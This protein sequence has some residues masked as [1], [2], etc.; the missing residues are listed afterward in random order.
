MIKLFFC[1]FLL[2]PSL[3]IAQQNNIGIKMLPIPSGK[4]KM[5]YEGAEVDESP[6]HTVFISAFKMSATEIT[7]AQY[8]Q[9]RPEHKLM[10]GVKRT[11][12]NDD[13]P[14]VFVSYD[15]A[16]AFCKW[17]SKKEGK[18]YR[19]PT[20]AEWEYAC[21][22]GTNTIYHTGDE[23]PAV[24]R[25]NNPTG[26]G[27]F[28]WASPMDLQNPPAIRVAQTPPNTWGLFDMHGNVEEWCLDAYHKY[29][30]A[31]Q[32]DPINFKG[33]FF[34]TRGGSHTA[35]FDAVFQ[36]PNPQKRLVA[37]Y[38]SS[39]NR[40]AAL[41]SER[42][43]LIGFRIVEARPIVLPV[44]TKK[45]NR[46]TATVNI[47]PNTKPYFKGGI[48]FIK[49]PAHADY[50]FFYHHH[51]PS[52]TELPN[53]DLL[54]IWYNT[55]RESGKEL[56]QLYARKKRGDTSWSAAQLFFD[57][58][59][60][61][62]HGSVIWSNGKDTVF[63]FSGISAAN[64]WY[65]LALIMRYSLDN[66]YT[67]SSPVFI[68]PIHRFQN[69]VI[70]SMIKTRSGDLFFTCDATPQ[71]TG[72]SVVW[73]SFDGGKTWTKP[74]EGKS[75]P[76]FS[77]GGSGAFIAG[78]HAPIA[79]IDN[80]IISFGRGDNL[81]GYQ[82]RSISKDKGE[83]WQYTQSTFPT[84]GSGQRSTL[85]RLPNGQ[86]IFVSFAKQMIY[87]DE[88][89][90]EHKASGMYAALS[91]DNGQSFPYIRPLVNALGKSDLLNAWGWQ[92]EFNWTDST[93]EPKGYLCS[94]L[95]KD[96]MIHVLSSGLEY[97]FNEAWIMQGNAKFVQ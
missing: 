23:L 31:P 17:L 91:L 25:K 84:I 48:S 21:R 61:N 32:K 89:G 71:G 4:F 11:S 15:D 42:N 6:V 1:V 60:R 27:G 12:F 47:V 56:Q 73:R 33:E 53:G 35:E 9:F 18:S 86:L 83:S 8:E 37:R 10:R 39:S 80:G 72:G 75:A 30:P 70:A 46:I 38:L 2:Y 64:T 82:I 43:W 34:V 29:S 69:Q 94:T 51:Q 88:R 95:T 55:V 62:E 49:E 45:T 87:T 68:D 79:E 66:G 3:I 14:V 50:P 41:R 44:I 96:G 78:I 92:H 65:A 76:T 59:D 40:S 5:G 77:E 7:N 19:L 26:G 67:W 58:P 52:V 85:Q 90:V 28:S 63:H 24:Y 13:D 36:D 57:V 20:E 97:V 22:A 81:N 54:S 74:A 93:A 16:I